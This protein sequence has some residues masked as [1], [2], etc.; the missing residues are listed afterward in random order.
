MEGRRNGFKVQ[1]YHI[2]NAEKKRQRNSES[3]SERNAN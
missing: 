1:E 3:N 2:Y